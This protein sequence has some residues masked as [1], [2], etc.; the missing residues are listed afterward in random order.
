[1]NTHIECVGAPQWLVIELAAQRH[2]LEK[3]CDSGPLSVLGSPVTGWSSNGL[4]LLTAWQRRRSRC[5]R[6]GP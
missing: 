4:P 5:P 2:S 3:L 6:A 1:L